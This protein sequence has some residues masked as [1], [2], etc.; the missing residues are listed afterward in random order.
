MRRNFDAR[1]LELDD[2]LRRAHR[3]V[4]APVGDVSGFIRIDELGFGDAAFG[5]GVRAEVADERLIIRN[6]P[7]QQD[8]VVIVSTSDGRIEKREDRVAGFI[9]PVGQLQLFLKR[10]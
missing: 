10:A 5:L 8:R 7:E 1:R 9:Q 3:R 4:F 6:R 2:F